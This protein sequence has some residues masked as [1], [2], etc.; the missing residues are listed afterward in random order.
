MQLVAVP[1]AYTADVDTWDDA[2]A[3]GIAAGNPDVEDVDGAGSGRI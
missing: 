1:A 3:L 2:A